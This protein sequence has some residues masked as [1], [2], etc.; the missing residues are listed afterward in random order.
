[1]NPNRTPWVKL[2]VKRWS[3]R[4]FITGL[5]LGGLGT[6]FYGIENWRAK[7]ALAEHYEWLKSKGE[8]L[9]PAQFDPPPVPDEDNAAMVPVLE[10]FYKK[11]ADGKRRL[12]IQQLSAIP[13]DLPPPQQG[14]LQEWRKLMLG[15]SLIS[16][17]PSANGDVD[18]EE[19]LNRS[20]MRFKK[21]EEQETLYLPKPFTTDATTPFEAFTIFLQ[22]FSHL[23]EGVR[24]MGQRAYCNWPWAADVEI[25]SGANLC[26]VLVKAM[27]I[28]LHFALYQ[29]DLPKAITSLNALSKIAW[30]ATPSPNLLGRMLLFSNRRICLH[31]LELLIS[32]EALSESQMLELS[33][34]FPKLDLNISLIECLRAD[35]A[36]REK[37]Y[38]DPERS[39]RGGVLDGPSGW[40]DRNRIAH[41]EFTQTRIDALGNSKLPVLASF[42]AAEFPSERTPYNYKLNGLAT[43][44]KIYREITE[45]AETLQLA[46]VAIALKRYQIKRGTFP[47]DLTQVVPEFLPKLPQSYFNAMV[48]K[49][50]RLPNESFK[51]WF[52]GLDGDDDD[53]R[54]QDQSKSSD[55]THDYDIVFTPGPA[56]P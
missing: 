26:Q 21:M 16:L 41:N 9:D 36:W 5:W 27:W 1:M 53:G 34:L 43:E 15:L 38:T 49:Y 37:A 13:P 47:E 55:E 29:H 50:R 24:G 8:S 6:L 19:R 56:I 35:R 52:F 3:K 7:R 45:S 48:P 46:P 17:T 14:Q 31:A 40:T 39:P 12:A 44:Q 23:L 20:K 28:D 22:Q 51:L 2:F 33:T 18:F 32:N 42:L 30:S 25:N 4:L 10:C 54:E 11:G